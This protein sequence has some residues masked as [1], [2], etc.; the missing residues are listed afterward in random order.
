LLA[1]D[2]VIILVSCLSAFFD[3]TIRRIPN[4]LIVCGLLC[5]VILNAIQ[6]FNF[7]IGSIVGFLV[8][9]AVLVLPFALGW[10]GAGDVKFFGVVG[11]LLGVAWLPRVFFYSALVAGAIAVAYLVAGL[12]SVARL[13]V[14][15]T[16]IKNVVFS[17]G[18]V[19]PDPV[20][21][22]NSHGGA[23]VPWGVAFA[24]GMIIAYYIDP[25]GR[26]AGF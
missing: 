22:R 18:H 17:Y 2:A 16:D 3:L 26:W 20:Y 8:G 1:S 15:W 7:L 13:R 14:V 11:A 5:G 9:V 25:T 4:W 6:G 10:I 23:S 12:A 21:A 19:L 24:A